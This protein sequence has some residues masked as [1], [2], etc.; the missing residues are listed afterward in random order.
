MYMNY[1]LFCSIFR[2]SVTYYYVCQMFYLEASFILHSY[3]FPLSV[4]GLVIVDKMISRTV[5]V[6]RD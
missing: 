6:I 2:A 5:G 4:T 1:H 3:A